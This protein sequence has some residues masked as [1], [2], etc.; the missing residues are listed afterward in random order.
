LRYWILRENI[1]TS[2]GCAKNTFTKVALKK[3]KECGNDVSTKAKACPQC[4]A[5][6]RKEIS[7]GIGCLVII[8]FIIL[9]GMC[10]SLLVDSNTPKTRSASN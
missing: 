3:C 2:I 9:L 10:S 6:I 4:G 8:G 5:P 7:A 1:D